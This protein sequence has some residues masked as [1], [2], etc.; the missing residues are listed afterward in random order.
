[1]TLVKE[2]TTPTPLFEG[3]E[4]DLLIEKIAFGGKALG[5]VDGF[6]IFVDQ[7]I[8]GQKVRVKITRK[9]PRFAEARVVRLLKQSPAY[10][11]PVCPHFGL[12]GGCSWQHPGRA[13][14]GRGVFRTAGR[15]LL[16]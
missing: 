3:S 5:R 2:P 6:V 10:R 13:G 12:C 8:P 14:K 15:I 7:A 11:S 1:M 9:K 4:F 16:C